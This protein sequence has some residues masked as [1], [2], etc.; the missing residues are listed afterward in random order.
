MFASWK[1][2]GMT[3]FNISNKHSKRY[4][5]DWAKMISSL[6]GK[7]KIH[8]IAFAVHINHTNG[9]WICVHT[10]VALL[11]LCTKCYLAGSSDKFGKLWCNG[12]KGVSHSRF[13][14]GIVFALQNLKVILSK[15]WWKERNFLRLP[16]A[17]IFT[18]TANRW[19]NLKRVCNQ[20]KCIN[21]GN[22]GN[23]IHQAKEMR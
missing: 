4:R 18:C 21:T 15:T 17:F 8:K 23:K 19:E 13:P 2:F 6:D 14:H 5:W 9:F 22:T 3:P 12:T 20:H 16:R 7:W 11:C 1:H 10:H